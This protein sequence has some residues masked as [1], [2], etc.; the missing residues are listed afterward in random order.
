MK[1]TVS[2][3]ISGIIFHIDEDAYERLSRYL[4]SIKRHFSRMEGRDEIITDIESRIAELLQEK[5][6][7][8]KQVISMEDIEEV[9]AMMGEPA[10]MDEDAEPSAKRETSGQYY[11]RPRRLYRDPDNRMIAGVS[12]GLAAYFNID[13]VW[14]RVL[15]IITLFFGAAG[16][17]AYIILWIVVPPAITTAEKLEMRGEPVNISNIERSFRDEYTNVKD[18]FN[19]FA[20][21][22]R[23]SFKKKSTGSRTVFDNLIEFIGSFLR[24]VLKVLIVIL[25]VFLI[26]SALSFIGIFV[27]GIT[28]LSS[29]SFFDSGELI[30]FS[31]PVFL[32]MIFSSHL[33]AVLAVI[34]VLLI[35]GIPLIA[36]IY[37][38]FRLL[39]G[40]RVRVP[41]FGITAFS[42]WL[43]G[44]ILAAIVAL[45]TG[46]DF[47]HTA[48]AEQ[49]YEKTN[50]ESSVL[51]FK[52]NPDERLI[53]NHGW[54]DIFDGEWNA[55]LHEDEYRLFAV[56]NL[57]VRKSMSD[58]PAVVVTAYAKGSSREEANSRAESLIYPVQQPDTS[59]ILPVYY[60]F[61][62]N[63]KIRNQRMTVTLEI[64]L[65]QKVY[66]DEGLEE[67][68][69]ANPN[70]YF[71]NQ[72]YPGNIWIMTKN[73]LKRWRA[74][75]EPE[76]ETK[77]PQPNSNTAK[78][79]PYLGL[80]PFTLFTL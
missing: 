35:I 17:L 80:I 43:A 16:L 34:S 46:M 40:T 59:F 48:M 13:P 73:G 12:S 18:K 45:N 41:Y 76:P 38:G 8:N 30:A 54:A 20:D 55:Y 27:A 5:I 22:A 69:D 32:D 56:P 70:Y 36:I 28:G 79:P 33:I 2:I 29:F 64:P 52:A 62:E 44:I 74:E 66:F 58:K 37:L 11:R 4:G 60:R 63:A 72:G 10:E 67:L 42:F 47:R 25:G 50:T 15:F 75:T 14:F 51:Y 7:D 61:P 78:I 49:E 57:K 6:K 68:F 24:V 53:R 9:I 31:L 39:L 19:E 71:R 26:I 23:E 65:G 21:G 77:E 1:K 3:N